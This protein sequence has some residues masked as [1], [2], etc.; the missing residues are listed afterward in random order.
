ME[1]HKKLYK[2]TYSQNRNRLKDFKAKFMA[3]KGEMLE[4]GMNWEVGIGIC[5]LLYTKSV[6]NKDLLYSSWKSIQYSAMAY[7]G[8]K[9]AKSGYICI[10]IT[11]SLCCIPEINTTL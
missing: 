1:S 10:C 11:D 7:I 6:G 4:G 8:K 3:T 2:S 9:Y 5:T